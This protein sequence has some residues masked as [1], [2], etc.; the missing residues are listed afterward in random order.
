MKSFRNWIFTFILTFSILFSGITPSVALF[1]T[2]KTEVEVQ[3][4]DSTSVKS[5][6]ISK[7]EKKSGTV[8]KIER[9]SHNSSYNFIFYLVT[10][11][12]KALS[13]YPQR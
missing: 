4:A 2:E 5:E 10:M 8:K 7:S 12:M 3:K 1:T 6:E 13:Y 11:I 9:T